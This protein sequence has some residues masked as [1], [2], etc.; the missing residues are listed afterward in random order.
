MGKEI[1]FERFHPDNRNFLELSKKKF[2]ISW[3]YPRK[4]SKFLGIIQEKFRNR[5]FSGF[6]CFGVYFV[7]ILKILVLTLDS[8]EGIVTFVN[9]FVPTVTFLQ[10]S[11]PIMPRDVSL[12]DSKCWN[13]GHEWVKILT[14]F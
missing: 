3:D 2:E 1:R 14:A 5:N 6:S 8:K 4:I 9:P 12:S 10:T 13:G 7:F 11:S